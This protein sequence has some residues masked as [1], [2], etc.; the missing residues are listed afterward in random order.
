MEGGW[1]CSI[2]VHP[3]ASQLRII[4][5]VDI[6]DQDVHKGIYLKEVSSDGD[7]LSLAVVCS[8]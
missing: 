2:Y 4:G 8:G 6:N 5:N 3:R 1:L 7:F